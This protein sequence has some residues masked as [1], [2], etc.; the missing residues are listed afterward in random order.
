MQSASISLYMTPAA[1]KKK[2]S[3]HDVLSGF[4]I[5]LDLFQIFKTISETFY[6]S[7]YLQTVELSLKMPGSLLVDLRVM[8]AGHPWS[9]TWQSSP[10]QHCRLTQTCL[11]GIKRI[12]WSSVAISRWTSSC[13]L[14]L[15]Y[16][17]ARPLWGALAKS[18]VSVTWCVPAK[19]RHKWWI[20][21][22]SV[23]P[24]DKWRSSCF[25]ECRGESEEHRKP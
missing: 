24:I 12:V 16:R 6:S 17:V 21:A 3:A 9:W 19:T 4:I 13:P 15:T 23:Q 25:P 8:L 10:V 5:S 20:Q 1:R 18:F 14:I 11:A 2:S 22:P 7:G